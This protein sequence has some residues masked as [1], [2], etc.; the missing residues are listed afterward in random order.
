MFKYFRGK[1]YFFLLKTKFQIP[2]KSHIYNLFFVK[3]DYHYLVV[4]SGYSFAL[5]LQS[6]GKLY[7]RYDK[8][9]THTNWIFLRASICQKRSS[10][11][12]LHS[13]EKKKL[14]ATR[15]LN[16]I[17]PKVKNQINKSLSNRIIS[18]FINTVLSYYDQALLQYTTSIYLC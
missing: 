3:E 5:Y 8:E 2:C 7:S 16:I 10:N 9:H 17:I 1:R 18:L 11:Y 15:Q 4:Y 6:K 13:S 12:V 14:E